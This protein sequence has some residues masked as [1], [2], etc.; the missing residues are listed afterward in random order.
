MQAITTMQPLMTKHD[1]RLLW[2]KF[3]FT[4]EKIKDLE[5]DYAGKEKLKDRIYHSMLHWKNT[6]PTVT[7]NSLIRILHVVGLEY[8]SS[9]VKAMKVYSQIIK[10]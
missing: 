8:L 10:L 5:K 7:V 9:K 1:L 6:N 3:Q 4:D 2:K